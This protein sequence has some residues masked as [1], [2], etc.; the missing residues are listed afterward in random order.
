MGIFKIKKLNI[1]G[2]TIE[3]MRLPDLALI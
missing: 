2:F 3:G 1:H